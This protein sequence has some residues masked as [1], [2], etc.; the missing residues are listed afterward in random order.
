M[1]LELPLNVLNTDYELGLTQIS[2]SDDRLLVAF[3]APPWGRALSSESGLDLRLTE[4]PVGGI[5]DVLVREFPR[6]RLLCAVQVHERLEQAS[7]ADLA[8][9]FDWS[10]LEIYRLNRAGESHGI[11][12]GTT[13]WAPRG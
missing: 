12:L 5:V 2:V 7:L 8:S 3:I 4:P 6:C 9:R 13:R 1:V 10:T 11:L